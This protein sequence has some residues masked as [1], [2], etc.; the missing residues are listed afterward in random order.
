MGF[1]HRVYKQGDIRA[2]Y[3]QPL[4]RELAVE[5]G[6]ERFELAAE[7]VELAMMRSTGLHPNVDWPSARIFRYLGFSAGTF[8]PLFAVSRICGW[9]AHIIEQQSNNRLI[10][11]R[12]SYIGVAARPF[13][14]MADRP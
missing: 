3:L 10:Q 14:Q 7:Q 6:N 12:A 4:C 5:T 1:G 11:P 13:Q 8:T 9:C 2:Q